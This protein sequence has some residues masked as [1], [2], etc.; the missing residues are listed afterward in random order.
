MPIQATPV[1]PKCNHTLHHCRNGARQ[2]S[3]EYERV[4]QRIAIVCRWCRK[5]YAYFDH[6]QTEPPDPSPTPEYFE[7]RDGGQFFDSGDAH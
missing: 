6:E 7:I 1:T 3:W 5:F 2:G 4:E